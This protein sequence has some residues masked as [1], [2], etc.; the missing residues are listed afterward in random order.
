MRFENDTLKAIIKRRRL[1]V[2]IEYR[3]E[4]SNLVNQYRIYLLKFINLLLLKVINVFGLV[5]LLRAI[6]LAYCP[7][8]HA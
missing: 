3:Y 8:G 4:Q 1:F 7:L 2:L 5:M 6:I